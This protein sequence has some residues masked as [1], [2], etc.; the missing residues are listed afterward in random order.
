M[1]VALSDVRKLVGKHVYALDKSGRVVS[2]KLVRISGRSLY[3]RPAEAKGRAR[4]KAIIPL[5]LFDLL[6][7]GTAPLA[8]GYGN[9]F[10]FNPYGFGFGPFFW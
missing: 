4:T 1:A 9:P 6:A 5:V 7:I 3:I 10:A 8:Y 2:G